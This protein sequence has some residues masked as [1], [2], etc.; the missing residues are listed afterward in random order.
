MQA[1]RWILAHGGIS[2]AGTLARFYLAAMNQVTWDA[3]PAMPV[4]IT[5][6]PNWF[7]VNM[8]ELSSWARGTLFAM[9][10]LQAKRPARQIDWIEGV[11]E[12]YIEPPHFTKFKMPRGKKLFSLRN[13]LNGADKILRG[14]EHHHLRGCAPALCAAPRPG[15]SNIRMPTVHGAV[16]SP[17]ISSV[18]WRSRRWAIATIIRLSKRRSMGRAN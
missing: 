13:A 6:L 11:L 1:R 10:V 5:L 4:E 12:L 14:Y 16:S 2:S 17:A 7:P 18:R 8:Y 15:C 9:M 3:T